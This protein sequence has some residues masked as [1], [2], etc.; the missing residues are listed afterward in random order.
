MRHVVEKVTAK[1]IRQ[2]RIISLLLIIFILATITITYYRDMDTQQ[3]IVEN[4]INYYEKIQFEGHSPKHVTAYVIR[5]GEAQHNI[6]PN[7]WKIRDP[8]LTQKGV[9][10]CKNTGQLLQSLLNKVPDVVL[11]SP[12]KRTIQS[13]VHMFEGWII[14]GQLKVVLMPE[15]QEI[16]NLPCDTGSKVSELKDEFGGAYPM[17]DFDHLELDWY[18]K[19]YKND[20]H[21]L[22]KKIIVERFTALSNYL[23]RNY[24]GK[25]VLIVAHQGV[26]RVNLGIIMDNAEYR[27]FKYSEGEWNQTIHT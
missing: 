14:D 18:V 11:V 8:S 20:D 2:R 5:H 17:I 25:T 26:F 24:Q 13:A 9:D 12:L 21:E 27:I 23:D 22:K 1:N 15:L 7:N 6:N 16:E 4:T 19:S 3:I 10:Q